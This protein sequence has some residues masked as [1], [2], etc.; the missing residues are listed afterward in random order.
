MSADTHNMVAYLNKSDVTEGFNQ[1]IDFL[2]GSYIK[3]ALTIN[4]HIYVSCIKQ[5]WNTVTVK[6]SND[7][8]RLQALV[9]RKKVGLTKTVIRDVLR[10]DDAEEVDCLPNEEIF[11]ELARMGYEKPSITLTFYKAFFSSQWKFLIHTI[12][13]SMSAKRTSWN[14]FSLAMASTVICM[15]TGRKFNFSKY[16]FESLVRNV[17]SSSKFYMYPRFLQLVI[18]NQLGN[19][20]SHTTKYISPALTQIVFANI[21]RVGKSFSG[22]ET[23]LFEGMLV[24]GEN[25]EEGITAEQVQDDA[26][27]AAAQEGV[28]A[29]IEKDVQE[30]SIPS[31]TPPPQPP[32]DLSS[33]SSVQPTPPSSP[34]SQPQTQPQA[35]DFPLGLL[36]TTLD[37]YAALTSRI[38][39]LESDKMSKALDISK[40]KKR[41]KRLEK[42]N[43]V[44]G[45]MIDELDRDEDVALTAKKEEERKTKE[46]KTSDGDDQ[47]KGRQAEIY[48]IDMDHPP[49]VLSMQE[50][51]PTEV[52][53]VVEVVT[54]AK[55]ITKVVAIASKLVSAASTTIP[56]VGPQVFAATPTVVLVRVAAA[57]TRRRKGVVIRDPKE[58]STAKNTAETK[59]KDKGKGIIVEEPKLIKKKQQVE[60]DKEYARKL[61]EELNQN[62]GWDVA[63][64]H[65]KQK[66]KEDLYVHRDDLESL[67]SIVKERFSTTKPDNFTDDFLLTTLR[68]MFEEADDQTQI[69]KNQRTVHANFASRKEIPTLKIYVGSNAKCSELPDETQVLLRFP[70]ENNMYN[71]NLKNVVPSGDLT[72]LFAKATINESNL[73]HSKLGHINFKTM[74]KL[75]KGN[76]VRGL[77]TKVFKNDT[78]CFACKKGKQ[79]RASCKTKRVSSVDQPLYRLYMDLFGPTFVKS[80]NKMSYCLVVTNDYSRELKGSLVSLEPLS[81][82][83]LLKGKTGP[84][85]RVLENRALVTKPHKKTPYELLHGRTPSIGF[86]RPFGCPVTILNTLDSL[87]KFDEKVDEGILVGYS[88]SSKAFRVFNN[89]T[90][91][92]QETLHVNFLENKP[93]V[94]GSGP[95][96]LFDIDT[97]TKTMNYQPVTVGNQSNPSA[98]FQDI[99]DAE[100]AGEES[101]QQY[102]RFPVWS[103]GFTNPQNTDGD[104]AFD[105]KEPEFD[106]KKPESKVNISPS[107]SAQSKKQDDKTKRE[108]KG[109]SPVESFTRFRNLSLEFEDFSEDSSN[110]VNAV[111]TL[112]P[113]IGQVSFNITNT[114]SAL[115]NDVASPTHRKSSCIDASQLPDDPDMPELEDITYSDDEDD[116]GVEANFNNLETSI[117]EEVYVCQPQGF[118]DPDHLNKVYK[119]VMEL[120]KSFK[121]LMKDKFQMSLMGELTFFLGLQVKQKKNGIFINQDK[122]V[123]EIL[124]KFRLTDGKS[125]STPIDTKKPLLKDPDGKDVDMHTYRSMIGSLI[126]LTSSRPDIMFVVCA[127][128]HFQVTPKASHLHAVMR[129]FRHLKG[130]PYLG[131]WYPKYSPFDLVAYSDSDYAGAS[132]DRKSTTG[133]LEKKK[134][135]AM[136][137]TIRDALRLDDAEGV[138]CI[139]NEEIFAELARMGYEKPSTKL[140]FYKAFFLSPWRFLIHTILQC[141]SAKRT[142]WDELS[143]SMASAI[144]CLSSGRKFNFSKYIFDSLVR[145]VKGFFGVETQLIEG[146]LV[147]QEVEQGHANENVENVNAGDA[148]EGDVSAANDEVPT[149]DEEP[150]IPSLTPPTPPPQPS[151]DIPSTS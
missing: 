57:S 92:V 80:L 4:P 118:E 125:A 27:V 39:Q 81:K 24:V 103:S 16:I 37:T 89:R 58:E 100:K 85:F 151:H 59:S 68:T 25:V 113:A 61:H 56:A 133:G 97:L 142:S 104:A 139:P 150:S 116:V 7:V 13:Q 5:F 30:Q 9:D 50:D 137:A 48:Q 36:Q 10:L 143:S 62:I 73:W 33:N 96:W 94:A 102:M 147:A 83:A 45:R 14:E 22:V 105:E 8:T 15:S 129:I 53:E 29:A 91:I 124:R 32:Q 134:V 93:N 44:K 46:A 69:W 117:T 132:L 119:V 54:T 34:Q 74:N 64:D 63:I 144:I 67:W 76:L 31:P 114:F 138:E 115:S 130:K 43:K 148:A 98:G 141:M 82:M 90:R 51:E 106:E 86:M 108:A 18:Q 126:Y 84:S 112:V 55:L 122:Y 145:N 19:L 75:V 47:V 23:P 78:T 109:K 42:G 95:I 149:A 17:D 107:S 70:R 101:D 121:K 60:M 21:R 120:R 77:P 88:V 66:A 12:L 135:S 140:T 35:T 87:G 65:V 123:A 136:K 128:A 71:V 131:L 2:N 3:Y 99:F 20:S 40:L 52:E 6:Q 111:G 72:R 79:H 110:E 11:T 146:M 26:D 49:K 41:V 127:C 28:I 1:I 38:E